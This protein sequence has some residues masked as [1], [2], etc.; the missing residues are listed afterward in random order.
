ME[1]P[2]Q[3][4]V[5]EYFQEMA[6]RTDYEGWSFAASDEAPASSR[7][8]YISCPR[9]AAPRPRIERRYSRWANPESPPTFGRGLRPSHQIPHARNVCITAQVITSVSRNEPNQQSPSTLRFPYPPCFVLD[10]I[11]FEIIFHLLSH[12]M[13]LLPWQT[14]G[15]TTKLQA[16]KGR[17]FITM[18]T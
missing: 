18:V 14:Q 16:T 13:R 11:L 6:P 5:Y 7:T 2:Q 3:L 1:M 10:N 8:Q 15:E 17:G 12:A 4:R 9:G